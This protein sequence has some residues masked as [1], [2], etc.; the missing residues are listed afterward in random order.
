MSKVTY[1]EELFD[2]DNVNSN[3]PNYAPQSL[4]GYPQQENDF[5]KQME[6]ELSD[7]HQ[8]SKPF[9]SKI[10]KFQDPRLAV[11]AG[12]PYE[13]VSSQPPPRQQPSQI[14]DS[15]F[16]L[17][18]PSQN[19]YR[20]GPKA[21]SKNNSQMHNMHNMHNMNNMNNMHQMNN[22]RN[23]HMSQLSYID[24]QDIACLEIAKH[25]KQCPICS[26]FY[27]NDKSIYIIIIV[28]LSICTLIL[29]KKVLETNS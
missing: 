21:Q 12:M 23:M 24:P 1:I 5:I 29:L 2:L 13:I 28:I 9:Q 10:R 15:D 22:M 14:Y 3:N 18:E 16:L 20:L 17:I 7:R 11:N 25:I 6:N 26:K 27:D 8:S 4:D 19:D